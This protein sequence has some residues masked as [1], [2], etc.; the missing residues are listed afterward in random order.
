MVILLAVIGA[1]GPVV[2][3][4]NDDAALAACVQRRSV[5]Q[6]KAAGADVALDNLHGVFAGTTTPSLAR[7]PSD[8]GLVPTRVE[9]LT[10]D[11]EAVLLVLGHGDDASAFLGALVA[12]GA[13]RLGTGT[14]TLPASPW[15]VYPLDMTWREA[16]TLQRTSTPWRA[17]IA[18]LLMLGG[19]V[20]LCW[21]VTHAIVRPLRDNTFRASTY[22]LLRTL[23][24]V[25]G[26]VAGLGA[27]VNP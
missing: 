20:P 22:A 9:A 15:R 14:Y 7:G 1:G 18:T 10:G 16:R 6:C 25:V 21:L 11:E 2:A 3:E 27:L 26:F 24:D 4:K 23:R 8:L 13:V 5:G 19:P 17:T 12:D